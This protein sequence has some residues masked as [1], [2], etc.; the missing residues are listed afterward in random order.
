MQ[1]INNSPNNK[2]YLPNRSLERK[3]K[4]KEINWG[5]LNSFHFKNSIENRMISKKK[6]KKEFSLK[7]ENFILFSF[8]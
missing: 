2:P 4:E 8:E 6:K 1:K 7:C 5:E 3:W